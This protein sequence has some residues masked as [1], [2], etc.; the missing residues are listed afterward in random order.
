MLAVSV[1]HAVQYSLPLV[2]SVDPSPSLV[3][4][5]HVNV[6]IAHVIPTM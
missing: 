6:F 1:L 2:A 3:P 5:S 4:L